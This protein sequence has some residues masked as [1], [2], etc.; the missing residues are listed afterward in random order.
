MNPARALDIALP[1]QVRHIRDALLSEFEGLIDMSDV[2]RRFEVDRHSILMQRALAAK[3]VRILTGASAQQ[4]AASITDGRADEGM[5]AVVFDSVMPQLTTFQ[6]KWSDSGNAGFD[7]K[8][9]NAIVQGFRKVDRSEFDRLNPKLQSLADRFRE[10]LDAPGCSV[11]I[12]IVLMGPGDLSP[13]VTK[14]LDDLNRDYQEFGP[15]VTFTVLNSQDIYRAIQRDI[16][17]TPITLEAKLSHGWHRLLAPYQEY[18]GHVSASQ[19]AHWYDTYGD[20]LFRD[21]MRHSLGRTRVNAILVDSYLSDPGGFSYRNRGVI[22]VGRSVSERFFSSHKM[23]EPITLE[24]LDASIVDGAQTVSS[25]AAAAAAAANS[26]H[27]DDAL[28]LLRIVNIADEP[29]SL[30]HDIAVCTNTHNAV[31]RRDH[32]AIDPIQQAIKE[33]LRLSVDWHY[34]LKRGEL[35][36]LPATGCSVL[37]AT[38]ALACAHPN[39]GVMSAAHMSTDLLWDD[40]TGLRIYSL[41][42]HRRP[43]ADHIFHC[44]QLLRAVRETLLE[45]DNRLSARAAAVAQHGELAVAHMV[46]QLVG[47]D[48]I[49]EPGAGWAEAALPHATELTCSSLQTL[50]WA[51]DQEYG[52]TSRIPAIFNNDHKCRTVV[53]SALRQ[54]R[55]RSSSPAL[56][57]PTAPLR[58][59]RAPTAPV[60]LVSSGRMQDGTLLTFTS[61]TE[62]ERQGVRTWLAEEPLR[63]QARWRNHA[64]R[65]LLWQVDQRPYT[66]HTLVREI[67]RRAGWVKSPSASGGAKQWLLPGGTSLDSLVQ[68]LKCEPSPT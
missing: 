28:V 3:A 22:V 39:P 25:A 41:L 2:V 60:L 65:P 21:N 15:P 37:E 12:V 7:S 51:I 5:D 44:V 43:T 68:E 9:A 8:A 27:L 67:W 19:L 34:T 33:D 17:P 61:L 24:V 14:I 63:A 6:A 35:D 59:D 40:T 62:E 46:F 53:D 47:F 38:V 23:G 58:S 31:E 11:A 32:V 29:N 42:F 10:V 30:I 57:A 49:D 18:I 4:A 26:S 36:P 64:T 55:S 66:L 50:V 48:G 16:R 45:Q 1:R 54:S 52:T 56:K 13:E 20:L